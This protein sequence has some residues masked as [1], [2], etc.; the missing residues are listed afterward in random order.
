MT[1]SRYPFVAAILMAVAIAA[2]AP[3][4]RWA[5]LDGLIED[6]GSLVRYE[7]GLS[8]APSRSVAV[9]ALDAE[10]LAGRDLRG[11]P[12]LVFGPVW[13]DL[14]TSLI[15]A[16]AKAVVF[17]FIF[18]LSIDDWMRRQRVGQGGIDGPFLEALQTHGDRV[19]LAR[20]GGV[21]PALPFRLA[22]ESDAHPERLG[23]AEIVSD[24]DGVAREVAARFPGTDG[25]LLPSLH[26]AAVIAAGGEPR[27]VA[28]GNVRL[29]VDGPL[30]TAIP[31]IPLADWRRCMAAAGDGGDLA[32]KVS[33][34]VV[35]IGS[36][37]A[38]EDRRSA[39][40]RLVLAAWPRLA[41]AAP[42]ARPACAAGEQ[43]PSAAATGTVPAVYLHAA[44]VAAR[45]EGRTLVPVGPAV[46][47]AAA[48]AAALA[49][50]LTAAAWTL[51]AAVLA[52]ATL[53][54]LIAGSS[55]AAPLALLHLPVSPALAGA[56]AAAAL[57]L[58]LRF[59][60]IDRRERLIRTAFGRYLSPKL[61]QD[62][63][64][65][66]RLPALGG[67]TRRVTVLFADIA[68][69]TRRVDG[70][71]PSEAIAL[72]NRCLSVMVDAVDAQAGYVDKFIGDAVMA[73]WNAPA[74]QAGHGRLALDAAVMAIERLA[75]AEAGSPDPL[76]FRIGLET[77][78][79]S[80][81]NM[82]TEGR[83]AYTAIG[84]TV[85]VAARLEPL[86]KV[87]GVPILAGPGLAAELGGHGL[88]V[89]DDVVPAGLSRA[90][91][92]HVPLSCVPREE[93]SRF[94]D[95]DALARAGDAV[96]ARTAFSALA[97]GGGRLAIAARLR[98]S[99]IS[100]PSPG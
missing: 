79:A 86:C 59:L 22:L 7:A 26:E 48:G 61:V 12:R 55:M 42:A 36:A 9:I 1:R 68:G 32:R 21:L 87:Y 88:L 90:I 73:L 40:D 29:R 94:A 28:P 83:L 47:R 67:E 97:A 23:M 91:P 8:D 75:M 44:A 15:R 70:R 49:A 93:A 33:G 43:R 64:T 45:L 77:G 89:L 17:D 24:P 62:L 65:E 6:T 56:F 92:V 80:V 53:L 38:E 74:A 31:T 11:T 96:S 27:L 34:K 98:A 25:S 60:V 19:V 14:T 72:V 81:G 63:A 76:A 99:R 71:P 20:S 95:A 46:I 30:E 85:N 16:G 54:I 39:G 10:S 5:T 82:G 41:S 69:Y 100:G 3:W 84:D 18:A 58:G 13:A 35:F 51:P 4:L 52:L 37:L 50:G 57:V 66:G 2:A 78:E